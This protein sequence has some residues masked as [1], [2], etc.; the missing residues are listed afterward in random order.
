M[1]DH[2]IYDHAAVQRGHE[3]LRRGL[4]NSLLMPGEV[5]ALET[6]L[7]ALSAADAALREPAEGATD[8]AAHAGGLLFALLDTWR[9]ALSEFGANR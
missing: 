9:R 1:Q 2:P 8:S 4:L 5:R 7:N 6:I 3:R